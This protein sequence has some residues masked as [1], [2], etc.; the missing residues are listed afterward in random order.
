VV[1][2]PPDSRVQEQRLDEFFGPLT[3]EHE[4]H[5]A[6]ERTDVR[7]YRELWQFFQDGL[8][9]PTVFRVGEVQVDIV[10]VG[11]AADQRWVGVKTRA[12]ET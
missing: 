10:I 12:I 9:A 1:D 11:K 3:E 4:W 8:D 6:S 5:G 2:R 7:R